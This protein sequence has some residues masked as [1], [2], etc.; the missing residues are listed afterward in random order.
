MLDGFEME[1]PTWWKT[2][3]AQLAF[4]CEPNSSMHFHNLRWSSM[5]EWPGEPRILSKCLWCLGIQ[6]PGKSKNGLTGSGS[7]QASRIPC[8]P[9]ELHS[10]KPNIAIENCHLRLICPSKIVIFHSYVFLPEGIPFSFTV[11]SPN[12]L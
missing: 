9:S 7:L 6:H 3:A 10:G 1:F 4:C 11:P 12:V 2:S 8:I 5:T